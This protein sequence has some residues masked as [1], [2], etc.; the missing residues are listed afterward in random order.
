MGLGQN[1][2]RVS[3]KDL[4][5]SVNRIVVKIGSGVLTETKGLNM[6]VIDG[7]TAEMCAL[8]QNGIEV[9]LVSSGAI[10]SGLK[11]M[12]FSKRPDSVSQQQ[13][14][15]AV[16]QSS[17]MMAYE[18]AF[19]SHG[20][21]V[22]Q[23]LLTRDDLNHRRR[24]LNAR[25]TLFTL[26]SWKIVPIINEND[27]VVVDEI[28]F[29]DND[30]LGAMVTNL[31]ESHILVN[32]TNI[33]GLFDKDPHFHNDAELIRVVEKVDQKVTRYASSIPGFLGTGGMV[34]KIRS[35]R[36]VALG[37]IP[38]VIANGL[39][40]GILG[41]IF[42]G[43]EEGT[44]FL[45]GEI[46]LCSRKHWI[47]FTKSPKGEVVID[48]GA[49]KAIVKNGKSLLPS[50]IKEVRGRFSLGDS[51]LLVNE[52]GKEIAVGM[53]NYHSGD[54]RKIVGVKTS[55]IA[56]RLGFKHDDEVMHRNNLVLTD[57]IEGREDI[58]RREG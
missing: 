23:V 27:T 55:E 34:S 49:E 25:N 33:D 24:Y 53:V 22:A 9:I 44:L 47:V 32:L 8:R 10:A 50:G 3:R 54:I 17:L 14:V 12:G 51:V 36:K 13:A 1:V 39:K 15:A 31:T 29:G 26:L 30:N 2:D 4:L 40:P 48:G 56:S 18:E 16:G 57:Q 41:R 35:A 5:K 19:G 21:K 11:K 7:L 6:A 46:P 58:C 20:Q 37:G 42:E 28:K 45:P 38:T 52:L 43:Q